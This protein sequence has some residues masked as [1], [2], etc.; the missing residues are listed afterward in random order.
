M[1]KLVKRHELWRN[2]WEHLD[3]LSFGEHLVAARAVVVEFA[4]AD[5]PVEAEVG[6][7]QDDEVQL[8]APEALTLSGR[9][10]SGSSVVDSRQSQ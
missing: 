5:V 8:L 1:Q 6:S 7:E 10:H 4:E 2:C 3:R 9:W